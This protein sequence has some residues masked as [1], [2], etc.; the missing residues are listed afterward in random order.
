MLDQFER[1][2]MAAKPKKQ[3]L[4]PLVWTLA[5]PETFSHKEK[6][7]KINMKGIKPPFLVLC[8]HNAFYDFKA[9]TRAIFPHRCNYVIAIDGFIG[10]EWL[11]RLVG[12]ICKRKF[13]FDVKL[14]DQCKEAIQ[15]KSILVIYPEARYS[16]CGTKSIIPKSNAR[17]AKYLDVPLVTF[18]CHGNH[19]NSPFYNTHN[20]KLKGLEATLE[21]IATLQEVRELSVD[22]LNQRI[23]K[24]LDYNDYAWQKEKGVINKYPKR[25]EGLHKVL[26]QCPHCHAEY[27]MSSKDNILTCNRCHKS[28]EM[29]ELGELKAKEGETEF[30]D[31]PSWYEWERSNVRKEI[32]EGKYHFES[33]VIVNALPNSK[34]FIPLGQG[35]LVHDYEG[36]HLTGNYQGEDYH[37][38]LDANKHYSVH[39]EYE[40]LHKYGDCIDLNTITDTMYVHPLIDKYAVTKISLA[41]EEL[42][43]YLNH[44]NL[45]EL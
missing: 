20:N 12:G 15:L 4:R 16:L 32:E 38:D 23:Q 33:D 45:S 40:Y 42:F 8:N 13:T 18:T 30:S 37:I 29:T 21:C 17:L 27:E 41:C 36:L 6:I 22:E 34:K 35:H 43:S 31:I 3:L 2:D 11:L 10:R 14:V 44:K 19:V 7:T 25:A 28:W 26:Y 39:I 24:S 9:L 1:F 5:L